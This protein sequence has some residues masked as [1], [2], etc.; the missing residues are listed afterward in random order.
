MNQSNPNFLLGEGGCNDALVSFGCRHLNAHRGVC[1]SVRVCLL[2]HAARA[3]LFI[4][5]VMP[6]RLLRCLSTGGSITHCMPMS[7]ASP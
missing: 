5:A 6:G 2:V 4:G 3:L 1:D 7:A